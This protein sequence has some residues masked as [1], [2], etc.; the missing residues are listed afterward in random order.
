MDLPA[1]AA[2]GIT[3]Y[4]LM[5]PLEVRMR[6]RRAKRHQM[7]FRPLGLRSTLPVVLQSVV[8]TSNREP[9]ET[10]SLTRFL[11]TMLNTR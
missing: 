7:A 4:G 3:Q 8:V 11:W 9:K 2:C 6:V 1:M 5:E 10:W